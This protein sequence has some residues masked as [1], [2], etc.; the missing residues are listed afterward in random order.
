MAKSHKLTPN[1]GAG[2]FEIVNRS[3]GELLVRSGDTGKEYRR[4]IVHVKKI[5]D[6]TINPFVSKKPEESADRPKR[7]IKRP[8][9]Y[10]FEE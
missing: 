1:F 2:E 8:N 7:E 3:G 5:P 6:D 4:N 10:G 9:R